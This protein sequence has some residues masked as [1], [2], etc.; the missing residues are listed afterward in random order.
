MKKRIKCLLTVI[1]AI[2]IILAGATLF[3]SIASSSPTF[4]VHD[5]NE[6]NFKNNYELFSKIVKYAVSNEGNL[7]I[8]IS[9]KDKL[10]IY[11]LD[12][13][14]SLEMPIIK[15]EIEKEISNLYKNLEIHGIIEDKDAIKFIFQDSN[16]LENGLVYI[17]NGEKPNF[18]SAFLYEHITENW[19]TYSFAQL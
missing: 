14:S 5:D 3:N 10:N 1:A 18:G 6:K 19:Y 8:N 15:L 17:K 7:N 9:R 13:K 4:N 11:N 16:G 12:E 2:M